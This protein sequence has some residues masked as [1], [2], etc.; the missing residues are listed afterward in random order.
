ME[1][2][3][4]DS[5]GVPGQTVGILISWGDGHQHS[6]GLIQGVPAGNPFFFDFLSI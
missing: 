1:P 4:A 5:N 2:D 3:R 6:L